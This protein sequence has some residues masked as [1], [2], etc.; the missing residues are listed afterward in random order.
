[1]ATVPQSLGVNELGTVGETPILA[2]LNATPR[3]IDVVI[4]GSQGVLAKGSLMSLDTDTGKYV[5]HDGTKNIAG[6]LNEAVDTTAGD[7]KFYICFNADVIATSL[8][9]G[10]TINLGFDITSHLNIKEAL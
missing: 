10:T 1:M 5:F 4:A 3:Q 7:V 9:S 8:V 6:Y 2:N